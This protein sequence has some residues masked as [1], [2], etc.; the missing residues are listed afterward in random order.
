MYILAVPGYTICA[1]YSPEGALLQCTDLMTECV[2]DP[3]GR[4]LY[5]DEPEGYTWP[6]VTE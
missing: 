3:E 2:Y 6:V 1:E 5:G 4:L